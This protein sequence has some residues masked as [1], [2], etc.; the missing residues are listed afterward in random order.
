MGALKFLANN[1]KVVRY[2]SCSGRGLVINGGGG[3]AFG[4]GGLAVLQ[5]HLE[6]GAREVVVLPSSFQGE[7][8]L[9]RIRN[10]L[11]ERRTPVTL[12]ARERTSYQ[13]LSATVGP[14]ARVEL[15][16]DMALYLTRTDL[17]MPNKIKSGRPYM[18]VVERQDAEAS[19]A[20]RPPCAWHVPFKR[21][22]PVTIKRPIKRILL[23]RTHVESSY[24]DNCQ[25]F[26]RS[27]GYSCKTVVHQ[28]VSQ[29]SIYSFR[30]FLRC[31]A[32]AEIVFTTRLH[33]AI[34]RHLLGLPCYLQPTGGAYAK[35]ED[36]Y[37][38]SLR[39]AGY[40][41]LLDLS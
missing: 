24:L 41:K 1:R 23:G 26:A 15:A 30:H 34:L 28:D 18:L 39:Q 5:A 9:L 22:I 2:G 38:H 35:N 25:R 14:Y 11:L 12:F 37:A 27:R 3:M 32:G 10:T 6:R 4:W 17:G 13:R 7:A 40:V 21:A 16:H 8:A 31:V 20:T 19:T 33:V 29:T 36:V